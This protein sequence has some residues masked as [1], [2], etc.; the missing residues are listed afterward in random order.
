MSTCVIPKD[1]KP[2][3]SL[4]DNQ[5]AIGLIKHDFADLLSASL[6]LKRVSAPL[7]VP[8]GL[9]LNDDLNGV[10]GPGSFAVTGSR[11]QAQNVQSLA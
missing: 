8:A 11:L 9:G 3:L 10:E 6:K 5:K 4:Y 2:A 1:Y 7:F